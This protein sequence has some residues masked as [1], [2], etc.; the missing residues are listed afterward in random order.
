[1]NNNLNPLYTIM[2]EGTFLTHAFQNLN[3]GSLTKLTKMGGLSKATKAGKANR[4]ELAKLI[5]KRL[6]DP[7]IG[8]QEYVNARNRT[9]LMLG[10]GMK[11][12]TLNAKDVDLLKN[13]A[14]ENRAQRVDQAL[15]DLSGVK[16]DIG[17]NLDRPAVKKSL[18]RRMFG[19]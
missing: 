4:R 10:S 7:T 14:F 19:L 15:R 18:L 5:K 9:K 11:R 8:G 13:K 2:Q 17:L 6:Y 3:P 12:N 16:E 1:M